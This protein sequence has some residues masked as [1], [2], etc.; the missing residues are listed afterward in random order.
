[1]FLKDVSHAALKD[2]IQFM[3][4]GEVNV[5]QDALPTFISTAEALQIKGLTETVIYFFIRSI[6]KCLHFFFVICKQGDAASGTSAP[7]Q[8]PV[9][10][11]TPA[12]ST[13]STSMAASPRAAR[14]IQRNVSRTSYK[15]DSEDSSDDKPIV[16]ATQSQKRV[17]QRSLTPVTTSPAMK[18]IKT[19][20]IVDPLEEHEQQQQLVANVPESVKSN[21]EPEFID[22]PIEP[23]QTKAEP[24]YGE[25]TGEV[26]AVEQDVSYVEDDSYGDMKYDESYF[27]ENDEA[28]AG[29]S[30]FTETSYAEGGEQSA[31]EAQ[32]K[33]RILQLFL[34]RRLTEYATHYAVLIFVSKKPILFCFIL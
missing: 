3:Y 6:V 22:L 31:N 10:V 29:A 23:M 26:E 32:G 2:L 14:S 25:D 15:I 17:I 5:K 8:S 30:G 12:P 18:R 19:A 28:K 24:D 27:T 33:Q 1:M 20:S 21:D 13:T 4:C 9:K 11:P 7:A 16:S 34:I